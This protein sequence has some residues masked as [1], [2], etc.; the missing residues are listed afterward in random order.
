[1]RPK[2][3]HGLPFVPTMRFRMIGR[4]QTR[5]GPGSYR[6]WAQIKVGQDEVET[7]LPFDLKI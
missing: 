7:F 6:L 1:M 5:P 4:L 2:G 3:I